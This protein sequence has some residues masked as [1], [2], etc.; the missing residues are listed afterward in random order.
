LTSEELPW[1][2]EL[3]D[4]TKAEAAEL[5]VESEKEKASALLI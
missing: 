1:G 3:I 5:A 4:S 2:F